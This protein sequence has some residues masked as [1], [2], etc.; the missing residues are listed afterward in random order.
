A[1]AERSY[2]VGV[3]DARG[4][5]V[6][7]VANP[8]DDE[9]RLETRL[10]TGTSEF[11]P[12]GSEELRIRPQSVLEVDLTRLL[13]S[14]VA[15][16]TRALLVEATGPVTAALRSTAGGDLSSAVAGAPVEEAAGIA[17]PRGSKRLVVAGASAPGV[18]RWRTW[19]A[20]GE[21]I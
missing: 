14:R 21:A 20:D 13:G 6:L 12:A 1:P 9:V 18:L 8:G 3:G 16:G 2:V 11:V 17:L 4:G 19:S 7:T 5:R 10:V 15:R